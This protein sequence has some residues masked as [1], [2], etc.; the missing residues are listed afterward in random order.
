MPLLLLNG[1]FDTVGS[2]V[3][4][5]VTAGTVAQK[6]GAP[7]SNNAHSGTGF[8]RFTVDNTT[9]T[10]ISTLPLPLPPGAVLRLSFAGRFPAAPESSVSLGIAAN[11][12]VNGVLTVATISIPLQ[13][14]PNDTFG[15]YE[16]YEAYSIPLPLGVFIT[17]VTISVSS[18]GA[19][20]FDVDDVN[21]YLDII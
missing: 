13:A 7:V 14:I 19:A 12:V 9:S 17:T 21:L 3:P 6:T 10:I 5:A 16:Y 20:T 2:L 4:F 1:N 18:G 8:A 11:V 15:N